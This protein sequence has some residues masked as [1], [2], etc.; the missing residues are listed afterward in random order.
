[1]GNIRNVGVI[2]SGG[3]G[4]RAGKELPKQYQEVCGK[5]IIEYVI[6]AFKQSVHTDVII[7]AAETCYFEELKKF[8]CIC[9]E[10]GK[11]RNVI[12]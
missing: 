7:V 2:L 5:M 12:N 8:G 6:D 11:E 4:V 1:M 9:V 3:R 10:G